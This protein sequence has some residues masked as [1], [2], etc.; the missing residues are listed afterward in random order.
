M[1]SKSVLLVNCD[2]RARKKK[3]MTVKKKEALKQQNIEV[4]P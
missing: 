2:R 1:E 4:P 3:K